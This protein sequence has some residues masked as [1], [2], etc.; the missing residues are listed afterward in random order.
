MS[1]DYTPPPDNRPERCGHMLAALRT[2]KICADSAAKYYGDPAFHASL[3]TATRE[4]A[5]YAEEAIRADEATAAAGQ[6]EFERWISRDDNRCATCHRSAHYSN[7]APGAHGHPY[8]P[9]E[10]HP[11]E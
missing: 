7:D 5:K 9:P 1:T 3:L 4:I 10:P 11:G 2:V 6:A 8:A